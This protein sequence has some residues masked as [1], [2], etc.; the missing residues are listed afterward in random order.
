MSAGALSARVITA[1][2]RHVL[3]HTR[4]LHVWVPAWG[5][6]QAKARQIARRVPMPGRKVF[7][8]TSLAAEQPDELWTMRHC[9]VCHEP[10]PDDL[11]AE[12]KRRLQELVG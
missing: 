3:G 11:V 10:H 4:D 7:E 12:G 1:Q 8:V 2:I 9:L 6:L 5:G